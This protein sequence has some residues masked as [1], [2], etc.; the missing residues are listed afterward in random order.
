VALEKGLAE[1]LGQFAQGVYRVDEI[2]EAGLVNSFDELDVGG[3]VDLQPL[4]DRR[5]VFR[6]RTAL[7]L[8]DRPAGPVDQFQIIPERV[9]NRPLRIRRG[10]V[11]LRVRAD[12]LGLDLIAPSNSASVMIAAGDDRDLFGFDSVDEPVCV[13]DASGPEAG[14]VFA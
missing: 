5:Q 14:Q 10:L 11:G 6:D 13:V 2:A 8:D 3:R 12:S 9:G 7:A 1:A 4:E